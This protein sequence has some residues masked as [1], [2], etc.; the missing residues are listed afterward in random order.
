VKKKMKSIKDYNLSKSQISKMYQ[1]MIKI[2]YFENK[3]VELYSSGKMP[4]IAHLYI[5]E[6]AVAVGVC[7]NLTNKDFITSTHRGHGHVIAQGADL[8][9]M[10]AE[11]LG[12][13][14]GYC[15]G[16][17][18]SMH[19]IDMKKGI[20][21]ANGIVAA[22]IPIATGAGYSAKFRGTDQVAVAFFGDAASNHGNF[23]ESLN[24][25]AA[26]KLPVIY[27]CENNL[28]GISVDIRKV[29]N[30]KNIADRACAYNIPGYVV[31]GNDVLNVYEV[32]KK[33]VERAQNKMGPTLIECKTYR[34]KGHHLGDPGI[35]YRP[36]EERKAWMDKC[37]IKRFR[38]RL[39][40]ENIFTQNEIAL[41]ESEIKEMIE[42]AFDFA[43]NGSFPKKEEAYEDVFVN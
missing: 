42:E 37:P 40:K 14:S 39:L 32:T 11:I 25:A 41:L 34:W 6:E 26:W 15:K 22:G 2:R 7:A 4:G 9:K 3:I 28:Y 24:M 19:I 16:K 5:G 21:G 36:E 30:T 10:M 23:H 18:G 20:L 1:G 17:G 27:V 38:E 31:D 8:K 12:K 29:T 33:A 35:I 43:V 13:R